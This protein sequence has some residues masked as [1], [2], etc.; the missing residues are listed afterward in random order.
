MTYSHDTR[1][2][3]VLHPRSRRPLMLE[4][5]VEPQVAGATASTMRGSPDFQISPWRPWYAS[6]GF[7]YNASMDLNQTD[8]YGDLI[9]ISTMRHDIYIYIDI[10]LYLYIC[11][12][13]YM[14][15]MYNPNQNGDTPRFFHFS[16]CATRHFECPQEATPGIQ[17]DQRE[18]GRFRQ[19]LIKKRG[20]KMVPSGIFNG[21]YSDLMGSYSDTMRY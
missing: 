6:N 12:Y 20:Q 15:G 5:G 19:E 16:M 18:S 7:F 11:M 21:I 8:L 17:W 4:L 10:Y 3:A 2:F 13:I 9:W 14:R 1:R